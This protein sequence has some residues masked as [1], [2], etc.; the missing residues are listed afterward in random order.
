MRRSL[1]INDFR[2][3]HFQLEL[4]AHISCVNSIHEC[5]G[6]VEYELATPSAIVWTRTHFFAFLISF[7]RKS[8]IN[9]I[10]SELA[11]EKPL[12]N[13]NF[14]LSRWK[15]RWTM[16]LGPVCACSDFHEVTSLRFWS[17]GSAGKRVQKYCEQAPISDQ[18][19]NKSMV[20]EHTILNPIM[21][22]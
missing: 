19:C 14:R 21:C 12:E 4:A 17:A 3:D 6:L 18:I 10:V 5:Y 16:L 8:Y 9:S 20:Y 1:K 11:L 13:S 15:M 2:F 7:I 22:G